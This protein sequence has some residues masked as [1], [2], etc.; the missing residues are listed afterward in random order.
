MIQSEGLF[1]AS[2]P[3]PPIVKHIT[4]SKN[5]RLDFIWNI[6]IGSWFGMIT[7]D[8]LLK[9]GWIL[10]SDNPWGNLWNRNPNRSPVFIF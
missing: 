7:V 10:L 5:V 3:L 1:L 6:Y 9:T 2:H 8:I 4:R